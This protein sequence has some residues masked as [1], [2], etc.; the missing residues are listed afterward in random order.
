MTDKLKQARESLDAFR[1][2]LNNEPPMTDMETLAAM[3]G[4]K[5]AMA[6]RDTVF[7]ADV[8]AVLGSLRDK[9]VFSDEGKAQKLVETL[10][11]Y[12][13]RFLQDGADK[14]DLAVALVAMIKAHD[15]DRWPTCSCSR[16]QAIAELRRILPEDEFK[17]Y[18]GDV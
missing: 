8:K 14:S 15:C 6:H 17:E 10:H 9:S 11:A 1:E 18:L 12:D 3:A 4:W 13:M 2:W 5:G 16:C 7:K